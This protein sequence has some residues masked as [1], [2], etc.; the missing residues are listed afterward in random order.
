L[1]LLNFTGKKVQDKTLLE[2]KTENEQNTSHFEIERSKNGMDFSSIGTVASLNGTGTNQYSLTD[3]LPIKGLNFYRLRQVDRNG[4]FEYSTIIKLL[5]EGYG[6]P[7]ILYPNPA[8][9]YIQF[10][11]AGKQKTVYIN[12]YDALGKEV[13][14]TSLANQAPLKMDISILS[15]GQYFI[16]LSDGE[17]IAAGSFIKQ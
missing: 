3:P 7:M 1:H 6:K 5:F 13:I 17:T 16:Q 10:D 14:N 12:V 8:S 4:R 2:W 15:K 11:F 9:N